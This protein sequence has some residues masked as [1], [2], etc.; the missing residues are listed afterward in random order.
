M[1][2]KD[3]IKQLL[4]KTFLPLQ[5][6]IEDESHTHRRPGVETHFHVMMVSEQFNHYSRIERHRQVHTL[7]CDEFATGLHALSLYLYTPEEYQ[8]KEKNPQSPKCQHHRE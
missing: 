2:R 6:R 8:K 1:H 5:L 7:L 4:T 3:R